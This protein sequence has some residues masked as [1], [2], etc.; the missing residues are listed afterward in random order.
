MRG[1]VQLLVCSTTP[2][3][4]WVT[5]LC[6]NFRDVL[7]PQVSPLA[8]VWLTTS[9]AHFSCQVGTSHPATLTSQDSSCWAGAE[10]LHSAPVR[11]TAL[12]GRRLL[13]VPALGQ[14]VGLGP[15]RGDICPADSECWV[16]V[17][18]GG[19]W[20]HDSEHHLL[21]LVSE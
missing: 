18:C 12:A 14:G 7:N 11:G 1:A 19:L 4:S 16:L 17:L 5:S 8:A 2:S 15:Q 13:A 20:G 10:S 21:Y 3:S 6:K 9:C